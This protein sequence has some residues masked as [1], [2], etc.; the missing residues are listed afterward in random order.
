[1]SEPAGDTIN[2]SHSLYTRSASGKRTRVYSLNIRPDQLEAAYNMLDK[3]DQRKAMRSV[4]CPT[5]A[6]CLTLF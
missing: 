4:K 1:M 6:Q 2:L 5:T 3:L